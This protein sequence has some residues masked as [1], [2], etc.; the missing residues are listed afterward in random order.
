MAHLGR[1]N[2]LM[3]LLYPLNE[4]WRIRLSKK[5][6]QSLL[7]NFSSFLCMFCVIRERLMIIKWAEKVECVSLYLIFR[8]S[9]RK[10]ASL[11]LCRHPQLTEK[12]NNQPHPSSVRYKQEQAFYACCGNNFKCDDVFEWVLVV[13]KQK[14]KFKLLISAVIAF[15]ILYVHV[16]IKRTHYSTAVPPRHSN[17]MCVYFFLIHNCGPPLS[18]P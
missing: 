13:D 9:T 16:K 14:K 18:T 10:L 6:D 3:Y 15:F 12:T 5:K 11:F 17:L 2:Y 1:F 4:E 8:R 7:F